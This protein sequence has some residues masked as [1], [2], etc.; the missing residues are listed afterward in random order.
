[1]KTIEYSEK[2]NDTLIK[3]LGSLA[4]R[5]VYNFTQIKIEFEEFYIQFDIE[6]ECGV[7]ETGSEEIKYSIPK[8]MLGKM[9][10][11]D[12]DEILAENFKI[13][14]IEVMQTMLYWRV[15]DKKSVS[16]FE[17]TNKN[18]ES[19]VGKLLNKSF[20]VTE[21]LMMKPSLFRKLIFENKYINVVEVGIRIQS[22]GKYFVVAPTGNAYGFFEKSFISPD[23]YT[24]RIG[25]SYRH[26][27][28]KT[29]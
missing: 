21:Q 8:Y 1:M 26:R 27:K 6:L 15:V 11:S 18:L 28:I 5:L 25:K 19:A 16:P 24:N 29:I 12:S 14:D 10:I 23:D 20:K 7:G 2:E 22:K 17:S 13:D 9:P 3:I 4:K